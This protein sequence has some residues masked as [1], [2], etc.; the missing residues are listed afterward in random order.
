LF[1]YNFTFDDVLIVPKFSEISSR[2]DVDTSVMLGGKI[3]LRVPIISSNMATI[4]ETKMARAIAKFGGLA[5]LHRFWS[6]Q[7][8]V[9]AFLD[10]TYLLEN[11]H[12]KVGV[13]I[14]LGGEERDRAKKLREV[15][16]EIF[17]IDIAH[18]AQQQCV[19][20]CIWLRKEFP[21]SF[22]IAGNFATIDSL[23]EFESRCGRYNA[24]CY[25]IGI[26]SGSACLTRMKSAI[27][28]PQLSCILECSS[29]PVI[30]DGGHRFPQ[31]VCKALSANAQAVMLG[32]MLSGTDEAAGTNLQTDPPTCLYQGSAYKEKAEGTRTSEG[33]KVYVQYKGSVLDVLNDIEGGLRS[34][35][36]YVGAHNIHELQEN[37]E[38]RRVS[39]A[40]INEN[41]AHA[42]VKWK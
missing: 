42:K 27:G 33:D 32:G 36:S 2:K 31:D 12:K 25:K 14:G 10:S 4:T 1:E 19:E 23:G 26:G 24:D 7:D 11:G 41:I 15:G 9:K 5:I 21:T 17:C 38:F 35:M 8:N 3:K 16:A 39:T 37:A 29:F 34:C 13:S 22:I 30:S 20:Q 40:T 18:G 6:I 28:L